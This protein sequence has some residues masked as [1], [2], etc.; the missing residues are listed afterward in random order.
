MVVRGK[1]WRE[2]RT[3]LVRQRSRWKELVFG[4]SGPEDL[5]ELLDSSIQGVIYFSMVSVVKS[6]Q[7]IG[8]TRKD[9][10]ELFGSLKQTV[11]WKFDEDIQGLPKN[12]HIRK[13][14]PQSSILAHPNLKVFITH[15]GLL[16]I[17][18]S[19]QHGVPLLAIPMFG[20]Q[21]GN[22]YR[23]VAAGH[24]LKVDFS[25]DMALELKKALHEMLI[26]DKYHNKAK[27]LSNMYKKRPTPPSELIKHYIEIAI[28][29]KGAYHLRSPVKLY[30]W[31]ELW[32][33]DVILAVLFIL[34]M[35]Y[36]VIKTIIKFVIQ[37]FCSSK[38]KTQ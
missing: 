33:L 36:Y 29:S 20:D 27:F 25:P 34:C 12:V 22:V 9:L 23:S 19:L 37:K 17:I 30:K 18:E 26:N 15:G 7:L 14:M 3:V 4:N 11:L 38:K 5:Q 32:M 2:K 31:Y 24:A 13:W 1:K 35:A 8:K 16:S 28:E 6:S 10:I 21:P